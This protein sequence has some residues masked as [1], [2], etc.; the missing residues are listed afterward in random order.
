MTDIR[1][2]QRIQPLLTQYELIHIPI[3]H[4]ENFDEIVEDLIDFFIEEEKVNLLGFSLGGY[5]ASYFAVKHPKKVNKLFIVAG[6]PSGSSVGEISKRQ[7]KIDYIHVNGF[8]ELGY[9]K[10]VSLLEVENQNDEELIQLI[11]DM[12]NELGK[13]VFITQLTSTFNRIEL[14]DHMMKLTMPIWFF[15]SSNDRLLNKASLEKLQKDTHNMNILLRE[16]T[17]HNIPLEEPLELS[18][19]IISWMED[20]K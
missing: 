18:K 20:K 5:I 7:K 13:N 17:S 9:E 15:L 1:L 10:T 6:T 19:Y 14:L 12:Y 3:P 8:K 16:G 2:W 11:Q 4:N